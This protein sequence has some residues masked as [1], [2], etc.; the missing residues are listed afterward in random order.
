MN[1]V[2]SIG[3]ERRRALPCDLARIATSH[4]RATAVAERDTLGPIRPR[5]LI[6]R[7]NAA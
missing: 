1:P 3:H 7:K 4:R 6:S 5:N 2:A